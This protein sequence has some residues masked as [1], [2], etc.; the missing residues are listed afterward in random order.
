MRALILAAGRG[1]RMRALTSHHPKCLVKLDGRPL[2]DWQLEAL[3][4]AG[5]GEVAVVRG[6]C[7]SALAGPG[8]VTFDNP[9]WAE[10]DMVGSLLAADSWLRA[11]ECIVSYGDI[12][13]HP[14]AVEA[15][16]ASQADVAITYDRLWKQLWS[17]RFEDPLSD[18][19]TFRR[20]SDGFLQE[21][22]HRASSL[23][24]VEGQYMGL[25]KFTTAGW[26]QIKRLLS[27]AAPSELDQLDM[28]TLLGG[29]LSAGIPIAAIPV[30]GRWCEVDSADD[31]DLYAERL[32]QVIPWRHDWRWNNAA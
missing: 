4:T 13:Y 2:L 27:S 23:S 25:L 19:E 3:Q 16:A 26:G 15:L 32:S 11:D 12:V 17:D 1:S 20:T 18:A 22:G 29:L 21:I 7:A 5:A 31:L 30:D 10:T 14:A 6:Y 24:D 8:Y 28:T 9:R